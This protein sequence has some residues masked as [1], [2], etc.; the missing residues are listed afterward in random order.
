MEALPPSGARKPVSI[1]MVVDLPAPLGPRNPSTSPGLTSK[2][3]LST[4]TCSPNRLVRL[5][6]FIMTS[7]ISPVTDT[8]QKG[9]Q[10]LQEYM[11]WPGAG[12]D[13]QG[14]IEQP[15][16]LRPCA[17]HACRKNILAAACYGHGFA[18]FKLPA[19]SGECNRVLKCL[20]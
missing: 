11:D 18:G 1:F 6:I 15:S 2:D 10:R 3:K 19:R 16:R 7:S 12:K 14:M 8:S 13:I 20:A 4:A 17:C 9:G 5:F